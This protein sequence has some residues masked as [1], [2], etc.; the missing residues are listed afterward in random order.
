VHGGAGDDPEAYIAQRWRGARDRVRE[1]SADP[2]ET[3]HDKRADFALMRTW[4]QVCCYPR[5]APAFSTESKKGL[6]R[7]QKRWRWWG[8]EVPNTV[9]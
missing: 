8:G 9:L 4:L 6:I 5:R 2:A 7:N 3:R 1:M